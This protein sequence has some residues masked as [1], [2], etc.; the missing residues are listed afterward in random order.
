MFASQQSK[1]RGLLGQVCGPV[2]AACLL[3]GLTVLAY[4]PALG[5]GYVFDD[6]IYLTQEK[7]METVGGLGQIWTEVGGRDYQHQYYPLTSTAFWL[8]R[9]MWGDN[10]FGYH[11]VNVL[12]HAVNGCLVWRL[13]RSLG[14]RWA[15][16][17]GA[18]FAL[19]PVNVQSVAWISEL[20]NVLSTFFFLSSALLFMRYFGLAQSA[21]KRSG[22]SAAADE[23]AAAYQS[24]CAAGGRYGAL[25]TTLGERSPWRPKTYVLGLALFVCGLAAKTATC[26]LPLALGLLLYWKRDRV[27]KRDVKALAPLAVL[28]LAFV[29]LT[30]Y[31]E[32]HYGG[33]RGEMFS[34]SFIERVLIAGRAVWF[35]G[36]KLLWPSELTFMYRR[37]EIDAGSWWQY[38]YPVLAVVVLVCLWVMRRRLGKGPFTAVAYFMLAVVPVSF[39]N[40]A[41]T[42]YSYVAD[43]WQ[44]W[45]S[46]GLIALVVGGAGCVGCVGGVWRG[47]GLLER[48]ER[49]RWPAVG[50]VV[51][52]MAALSSVTWQRA[53]VYRSPQT[54]WRDTLRKN[55]DAWAA[56]NNLGDTLCAAGEFVEGIKHFHLSLGVNPDQ[57]APHYN[58][59]QALAIHGKLK[60][61]AYH[62]REAIR[63]GPGYANTYNRLGNVLIAQGNPK[64]AIHRFRQALVLKPEYADAHYNLAN[65]LRSQGLLK[66]AMGHYQQTLE[67]DPQQARAHNN[68]GT[69][70]MAQGRLDDASSHLAEAV[71]I[72][73][74]EAGTHYNLGLALSAQGGTDRAIEHYR[75]A[76]ALAPD[77]A[78]IHNNLAVA[79]QAQGRLANAVSHYVEALRLDPAYAL[80][81]YNL[82]GALERQGRLA[83]AIRHYAVAVAIEPGFDAA[84]RKLWMVQGLD[85]HEP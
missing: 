61:G 58:L 54:L 72:D 47:I 41:F 57:P 8:Q 85:R 33:A 40:V 82:A 27:T 21:S 77:D 6:H 29:G 23:F 52:V 22:R 63:L 50:A 68:L 25:E 76:L 5:A 4:L 35:Y 3:L 80:A 16:V 1:W 64:Q 49:F 66:S 7:R 14:L 36:A 11:F 2:P 44:Y 59:A 48:M 28:G 20:K 71:R 75:A 74:S 60:E 39:V 83:D 69:A 62:F 51:V 37:W 79:L 38:L 45:A 42:R 12:L 67:T 56:H 70:L 55:P 17:A 46:M 84:Q 81:Y 43:H 13:L 24:E 31:L 26:L 34:Q 78:A 15:W 53:G 18:I 73:P 65:A 10:P 30:V 9:R 32:S 19:H